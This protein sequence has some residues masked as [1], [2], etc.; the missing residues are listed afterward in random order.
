MENNSIV[1]GVSSKALHSKFTGMF[2]SGVPTLEKLL[3]L[4]KAPTS[5]LYQQLK[6]QLS[7]KKMLEELI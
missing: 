2:D 6:L 5:T 1:I 7:F 4:P 3:R